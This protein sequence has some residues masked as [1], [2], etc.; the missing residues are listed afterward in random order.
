MLYL[1]RL[2]IQ[3]QEHFSFKK[4]SPLLDFLNYMFSILN[5]SDG[6]Q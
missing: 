2:S 6:Y 1:V 5:F 3:L 4:N